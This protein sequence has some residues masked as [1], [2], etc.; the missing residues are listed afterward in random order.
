MGRVSDA[1]I[2]QAG[3]LGDYVKELIERLRTAAMEMKE[4]AAATLACLADQASAN[5]KAIGR[6]M[7]SA[8]PPLVNLVHSGS[9]IA[10]QHAATVLAILARTSMEFKEAILARGAITPLAAI[11]RS[12]GGDAQEAA[13]SS[14][15]NISDNAQAQ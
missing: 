1:E 3:G 4:K 5:A 14:F 6:A 13:A 2:E 7:P 15:A 11:L 9:P 10:Q 12:G 8:V